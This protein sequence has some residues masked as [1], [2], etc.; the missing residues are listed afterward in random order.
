MHATNETPIGYIYIFLTRFYAHV[1]IKQA[2]LSGTN[3]N[4]LLFVVVT[5]QEHL[6]KVKKRVVF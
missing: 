3:F 5:F 6:R 1:N 2:F 4:M